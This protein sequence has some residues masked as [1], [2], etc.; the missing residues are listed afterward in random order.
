[1][2]FQCPAVRVLNLSQLIRVFAIA[3]LAAMTT[4]PAMANQ[5]APQQ[6][7]SPLATM[8]AL[9]AI[10]NTDG[11]FGDLDGSGEV[12]RDDIGLMLV[13]YGDCKGCPTDLDGSGEVDYGDL[14]MLLLPPKTTDF[15]YVEQHPRLGVET[16]TTWTISKTGTPGS[17]SYQVLK[18]NV[19]FTIKGVCYSPTEVGGSNT[20]APNIGDWFTDSVGDFGSSGI[21][22]WSALWGFEGHVW[23]NT[24]ID[25]VQPY[26][27]RKDLATIKGLGFNAIRLYSCATYQMNA[28]GTFPLIDENTQKHEHSEFL[29]ECQAN[30]IYVLVGIPVGVEMFQQGTPIA[31]NEAAFWDAAV[32]QTAKDLCNH[33]AVMGFTIQNEADQGVANTTNLG[34][35]GTYW[36]KAADHYAKLVKDNAPN[37][38][39]GMADHDDPSIPQIAS[40]NM[41]KYGKNFDFWGVNS[42]QPQF[43]GISL[44]PYSKSTALMDGA[45]P[46]LFTEYG[47]PATGQHTDN[48]P[49][50]IFE[51]STTRGNTARWLSN[52]LSQLYSSQ[53]S[54]TCI[55][56]FIFE[57]NDEW[58]N[59][60]V[61]VPNLCTHW[62]STT[63]D[64]KYPNYFNHIQGYGLYSVTPGD[65]G[66]IAPTTCLCPPPPKV[67]PVPCLVN[68]AATCGPDSHGKIVLE[69]AAPYLPLD[70]LTERTEITAAIKSANGVLAT[71]AIQT[72]RQVGTNTLNGVAYCT[73]DG[74]PT[75]SATPPNFPAAWLAVGNNGTAY[76]STDGKTW[77]SD[78]MPTMT[79]PNPNPNLNGITATGNLLKGVAV[80]DGGTILMRDDSS[81]FQQTSVTTNNLNGVAFAYTSG[82]NT[83]GSNN[84]G[85][86]LLVA[87][88]DSG[89]IVTSPNYADWTLRTSTT[90]K[91]LNG[92]TYG[93]N[94]QFVAVGESGTILT[95]PDGVTWRSQTLST[96][97]KLTGVTYGNSLF[98]A[99]GAA[100]TILTSP[101]G[102]TWTSQTYWNN[103]NLNGVTYGNSLFVAVGAAGTCL[104][105]PDGVTWTPKT[106][107]IGVDLNSVAPGGIQQSSDG[108]TWEAGFATVGVKLDG[109]NLT[110]IFTLP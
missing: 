82:L 73:L 29:D 17:F 20:S 33:P 9:P 88:G 107:L 25:K 27:G 36:W 42:Y 64:G 69:W 84:N 102:V 11:V 18:N 104:T 3:G 37:K 41:N 15:I 38:L 32:T 110:N 5:L 85:I 52:G 43:L 97:V 21:S 96:T 13:D 105:S 54:G 103:V 12:D 56:A 67:C 10:A 40:A 101:D 77:T 80:G 98:V 47:Y 6:R 95:S 48:D 108:V 66:S 46:V 71:S 45:H 53:N 75:N 19:P 57:F 14:G 39:V 86:P 2:N 63:K 78:T 50:T 93:G 90:T 70:T 26:N 94:S 59:N 74:Q 8:T 60:D 23:D 62:G 44:N 83:D 87:V 51:N 7:K 81:W 49:S 28:D 1:M 55:G 4:F 99:V 34:E 16:K 31:D 65:R 35:A 92:V 79:P 68:Y 22:N 24:Q 106:M 58:W 91:N 100:G 76:I 109:K 30:G 61:A 72:P 89:T